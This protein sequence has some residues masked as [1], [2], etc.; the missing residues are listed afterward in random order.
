MKKKLKSEADKAA[1]HL[2]LKEVPLK[3]QVDPKD[4]PK[5]FI[6]VLGCYFALFITYLARVILSVAMIPMASQYG[7]SK[8]V[9]GSLM[10]AFYYGYITTQV[11]AG[12]SADKY[13]GKVV[14]ML[15]V[16]GAAMFSLAT[17]VA[18]QTGFPFL[19]ACRAAT[20]AAAGVAFPATHHM[21]ACWILPCERSRAVAFVGSG[22]YLAS[23]LC[24]LFAPLLI[25]HHGYSSVFMLTGLVGLVWAAFWH[26][27]GYDT[28]SEHPD[29]SFSELGLLRDA[30]H[31]PLGHGTPQTEETNLEI[32]GKDSP[33][34]KQHRI[35]WGFILTRPPVWALLVAHFSY[36]VAFCTILSWIP[37]YFHQAMSV[38]LSEVGYYSVLPFFVMAIAANLGGFL[39][40]HLFNS[41][42]PLLTVRKIMTSLGM[43]GPA[44]F[45]LILCCL[46]S[47]VAAVVCMSVILALGSMTLGGHSVNHLDIGPKYAGVL[48]GIAGI[49][50]TLGAIC[51]VSG[52][53][54]VLDATGSWHTVFCL[55]SGI[56]VFGST[57]FNLW[58]SADNIMGD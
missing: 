55:L 36:S 35:P 38:P 11:P 9:Q 56:F 17:P 34:D 18:A 28:P 46:E 15:G 40:D 4:T 31:G 54:V 47:A 45:L 39:A 53:G 32:Y 16:V 19:V 22:T 58:A 27:I 30:L 21:F 51:G 41:G 43:L 48:E 13:G 44:L 57:L 23:G 49:F 7:W 5:R 2:Q 25:V 10:A 20:G 14:L 3:E 42:Y 33:S 24:M 8:K 37:S 12:L 52:A 50:S 1:T 29:I 26:V 6:I